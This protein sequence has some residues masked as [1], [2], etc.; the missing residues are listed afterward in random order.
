MFKI[1]FEQ[2]LQTA[3]AENPKPLNFRIGYGKKSN[4]LVARKN[5][6]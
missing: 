4:L 1:H 5:K 2:D 6:D 3:Y